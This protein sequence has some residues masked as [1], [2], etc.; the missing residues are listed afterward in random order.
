MSLSIRYSDPAEAVYYY[1]DEAVKSDSWSAVPLVKKNALYDAIKAKL[2]TNVPVKVLEVG[3]GVGGLAMRLAQGNTMP[4][5]T[6][7]GIDLSPKSIET[8]KEHGLD[9]VKYTFEVQNT[10][11][12]LTQ[13]PCDWDFLVSSMFLFGHDAETLQALLNPMLGYARKGFIIAAGAASKASL[14]KFTDD[15]QDLAGAAQD[16]S[17]DMVVAAKVFPQAKTKFSPMKLPLRARMVE[18][19][20]LNYALADLA[21]KNKGVWPVS[22]QGVVP[23]KPLANQ[24][25]ALAGANLAPATVTQKVKV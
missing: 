18:T 21:F 9:P 2:P 20:A 1:A 23:Q 14:M 10:Y 19:G 17:E 13:T 25:G 3:C 24:P 8:A 11:E 6:Y 12:Y 4:N 7:K 5:L 22:V 16:G 15:I